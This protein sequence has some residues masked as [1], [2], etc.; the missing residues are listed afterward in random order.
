RNI[1]PVARSEGETSSILTISDQFQFLEE[2]S[3]SFDSVDVHTPKEQLPQ[4]VDDDIEDGVDFGVSDD[5]LP[6]KEDTTSDLYVHL[7]VTK[8]RIKEFMDE[9]KAKK[10]NEEEGSDG[11][12]TSYYTTSEDEATPG[13]DNKEAQPKKEKRKKPKRKKE[14]S[15]P[16]KLSPLVLSAE[17]IAPGEG[18]AD[19]APS[20]EVVIDVERILPPR[21]TGETARIVTNELLP[22]ITEGAEIDE[23]KQPN[24]TEEET[25][26]NPD[27]KVQITKYLPQVKKKHA[28]KITMAYRMIYILGSVG[29]VIGAMAAFYALNLRLVRFGMGT[30][31]W[32]L[33]VYGV[34]TMGHYISESFF[35]V[36]NKIKMTRLG[37]KVQGEQRA[38]Y[39]CKG[40]VALQIVGYR[41]D[42]DY[43]RNCIISARDCYGPIYVLCVVVDGHEEQDA[44]MAET[45]TEVFGHENTMQIVLDDLAANIEEE[46]WKE[47]VVNPVAEF[48]G[49]GSE[50]TGAI[51][52]EG[53][54]HNFKVLTIRQFHEGKRSV[55]HCAM[56]LLIDVGIDYIM[57]TDS[58]TLL[59]PNC[60]AHLTNL[61]ESDDEL[62]AV[63]GN[64]GIFNANESPISFLSAVKY[65]YAFNIE[66]AAQSLFGVVSC[67]SG[68]L[69]LYR[70][71]DVKVVLH[72]WY[73]QTFLGV[74]C[75][76]GDD[77]HLTNRILSLGR[78]VKYTHLATCTTE[79]PTQ[80]IRWIVQQT[81]WTK[82]F[83][84][85]LGFNLWW[86]FKVN[87][88]LTWVLLYQGVYPFFVSASIITLLF[89]KSP[90]SMGT[91]LV[92][93]VAVSA[94][95]ATLATIL[96][97]QPRLLVYIIYSFLYVLFMIPTKM[98]A[99]LMLWD[100]GW[101]TS[102]RLTVKK[103]NPVHLTPVILWCSLLVTG[104]LYNLITNLW[105]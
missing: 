3:L 82:S 61:L 56:R 39:R 40:K 60:L 14:V 38:S 32:A 91:L 30:L 97:R 44:Y 83:F 74:P 15:K 59:E 47:L 87:F 27:E 29:L 31:P 105:I 50:Y 25:V 28:A 46:A 23:T 34:V 8:E 64:V 102:S 51:R 88:Y 69:G 37:L 55:M 16:F 80:L 76:Y 13:D 77:R 12:N 94:F 70:T 54:E 17:S 36:A 100:T 4:V 19:M 101:G 75:T 103:G 22:G 104:V 72:D 52:E 71:R 45:I 86:A 21:R 81:R 42:P 1:Y 18:P 67:V 84:R 85:E 95:R 89:S 49:D 93:M 10:E 68:P 26:D 98:H 73:F 78:T 2:E 92:V 11:E 48:L 79:T 5:P 6:E 63:T 90:N 96:S 35:A 57:M 41:E 58:D 24:E 20:S 7:H 43:F 66:R 62:G 9:V 53:C 65:W 33:T 99:V